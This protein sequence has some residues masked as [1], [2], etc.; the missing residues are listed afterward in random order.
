MVLEPEAKER[1]SKGTVAMDKE[2]TDASQTQEPEQVE[3]ADPS[4]ELDAD[5]FGVVAE[6]LT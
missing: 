4:T 5:L 3:A 2:T 1:R 6:K